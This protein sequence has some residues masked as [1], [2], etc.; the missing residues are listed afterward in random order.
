MK[1]LHCL[2]L[3]LLLLLAPRP[4]H[5]QD[6]DWRERR[7]DRFAILYV[8]GDAATAEHYADFVDGVYDEVAA[9]FGHAT[10]V[11]VT[12]RLY[13]TLERYQQVNPLARELQGIVAHADYR[14]HEVVVVL[15]QTARQTEEEVRNNVRHELTHI[16][17][18]EVSDDRLNVGFQEGLA[19]YVE[20]PAPEL[21]QRVAL[22]RRA[23]DQDVLLPW[24]GLDD[25]DV[26]YRAPDVSYPESLS[27]VA[28][29]VERYSFAKLRDFLT[30]AARS[31]GYRSAL[32]RTYGAAPDELERQWRDWL[33]SYLGGGYRRNALAAYDLSGAEALLR[34]GRYAAAHADLETAIEWLRTTDQRDVLGQAE[35]LLARSERGLAAEA[36]ARDARAAL[37][38]ADYGR[39]ADLVGQAR[40]AYADL[41]DVHQDAALA[42]FAE[43]AERG[44]SAAAV[45]AQAQGLARTL[46]YPQARAAAD[47]AAAAYMAL[48]DRA[49]ADEA[50]ALRAF[51][52]QRQTWLGVALLLLGLG[53]VAASAMR[54]LTAR[55][56]EAW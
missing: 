3:V 18:A 21:E 37:E 1:R 33:P 11:P 41:G 14:R 31:S 53:G 29:L 26:V 47:Q 10:A 34:Q 35:D 44:T 45:L 52:D 25:R 48:G 51:L 9:I 56:A 54:R 50:L 36:L 46:R 22:L 55:E 28:F 27:I 20:R 6:T 5:A 32:E 38:A 12:L 17:A 24:S 7:T 23:V 13:P 16:V 39:A 43:R 30:I 49:R 19:Q 15:S 8:D 40:R 4:A 2:F 42:A